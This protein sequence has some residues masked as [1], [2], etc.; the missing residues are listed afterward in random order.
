LI[1]SSTSLGAA[2]VPLVVAEG[3]IRVR[4]FQE[5]FRRKRS[6]SKVAK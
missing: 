6:S 5:K 2:A 4:G 3:A 1:M